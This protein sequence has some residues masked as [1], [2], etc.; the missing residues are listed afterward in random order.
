MLCMYRAIMCSVIGGWYYYKTWYSSG[1]YYH[2]D[3]ILAWEGGRWVKVG[4]MKVAR[5]YHAMAITRLEKVSAY[6]G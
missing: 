3:D 2:T 6:C 4:R 5:G 1:K